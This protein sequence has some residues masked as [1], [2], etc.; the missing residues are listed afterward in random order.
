MI[1]GLIHNGLVVSCFGILIGMTAF[2][3][4]IPLP[5]SGTDVFLCF[6]NDFVVTPRLGG[7]GVGGGGGLSSCWNFF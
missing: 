3:L 4:E 2:N 1:K 5:T 7:G 6:L